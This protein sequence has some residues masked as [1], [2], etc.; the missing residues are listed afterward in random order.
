MYRFEWH[1]TCTSNIFTTQYLKLQCASKKEQTWFVLMCCPEHSSV[2][3]LFKSFLESSK[4]SMVPVQIRCIWSTNTLQSLENITITQ[5]IVHAQLI[6][7]ENGKIVFLLN[8]RCTIFGFFSLFFFHFC[9]LVGKP[10]KPNTKMICMLC[11]R[12]SI[13]CILKCTSEFTFPLRLVVGW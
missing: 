6:F 12:T 10:F 11:R 4:N 2:H 5:I 7:S 3:C 1:L 8:T 13:Y 9:K